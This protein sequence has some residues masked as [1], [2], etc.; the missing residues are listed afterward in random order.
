VHKSRN[1][2]YYRSELGN[3][4]C[5]VLKSIRGICCSEDVT[6]SSVTDCPEVLFH[7]HRAS[8]IAEADA[9]VLSRLLFIKL[10]TLFICLPN[11]VVE[12]LPM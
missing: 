10:H 6:L 5:K 4:T 3:V 8:T 1:I 7:L 9:A 12:S 2:K 11:T